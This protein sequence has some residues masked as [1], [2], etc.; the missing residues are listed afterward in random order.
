[1]WAAAFLCDLEAS[2]TASKT[3]PTI[4]ADSFDQ[5]SPSRAFAQRAK[6]LRKGYFNALGLDE[7]KPEFGSANVSFRKKD[8]RGQPRLTHP[9]PTEGR[10]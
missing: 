7:K 1:M 9:M 5:A 8:S 6:D 4:Q 3:T 10:P 2:R